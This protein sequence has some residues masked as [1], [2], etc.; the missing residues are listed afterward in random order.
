MQTREKSKSK[1]ELQLINNESKVKQKK[2]KK[3][4]K[5]I[6]LCDPSYFKEE[7]YYA[8]LGDFKISEL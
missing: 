7:F 8:K 6:K 5:Q 1:Q 3:H 2:K 4:T